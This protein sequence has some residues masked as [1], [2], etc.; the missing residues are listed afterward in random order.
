MKKISLIIS[1][2]FL[3]LFASMMIVSA[4]E[5][6]EA[7]AAEPD[8]PSLNEDICTWKDSS[9]KLVNYYNDPKLSTEKMMIEYHKRT[10]DEFNRYIK[11][12]ISS[13]TAAAEA[14][15]MVD[16]N[17]VAPRDEQECIDNPNNYSTFCVAKNLLSDKEQGD[18]YM[19]YSRALSCKRGKLFDTTDEES[20]WKDWIE[21]S[22]CLGGVESYL[23][24]DKCTEEEEARLEAQIKGTFQAQKVM[25]VS[26]RLDAIKREIVTSKRA[27]DQ[28]LAAYN[29]LKT[30]WPMHKQYVQIYKNL[31]EYRNKLVEVRHHVEEYPSKFI[32]ATTTKCS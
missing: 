10:N 3:S 29:E 20:L 4:F 19:E 30:A 6:P 24:P 18:G 32:D 9:G 16:P 25:M 31:V 13:Q 1:L 8:A 23:P 28:T 22:T 11:L 27:L 26:A 17:S 2:G 15:S 5:S 14:G 12:M 7:N 21:T